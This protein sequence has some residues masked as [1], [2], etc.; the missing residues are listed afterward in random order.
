LSNPTIT[1]H[2]AVTGETVEREM[3]EEEL[4]AYEAIIANAP[5][6]PGAE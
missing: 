5:P 4:A 2:D 1:I 6:L 3:S